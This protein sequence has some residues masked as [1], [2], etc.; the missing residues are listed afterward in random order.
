MLCVM[1]FLESVFGN[2]ILDLILKKEYKY[3]YKCKDL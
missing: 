1:K 2:G 3:I